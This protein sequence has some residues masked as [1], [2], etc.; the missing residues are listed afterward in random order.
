MILAQSFFGREDE[1]PYA[2]L[3]VFEENCSLLIIPGMTQHTLRWKLFPFSLTGGAKLWYNRTARGV[4]GDLIQ[5]KDEFF[6]FFYPISKV[7]AHQNQLMKFEQGDES[8]G[9]AWAR[10]LHLIESGPLHQI[11]EEILMQHFIYGLKPESAYFLNVSTEGSVMYKTVAEV[12]TLLKKVLN[13]TEYTS[14]YDDPPETVERPYKTQQLQFI[15]AA[16]SPPPPYIE[17]ITEPPKSS[18]QEPLQEDIPMFLPDLFTEE[19][20]LELS[21]V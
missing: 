12:R 20:Y 17:E 21:N 3:Q 2:H 14:I 1:C 7:I 13:S 19:E 8:L 18:D 4:G 15:T 5:L 10:F 9:V 16:S 11:S 6:L